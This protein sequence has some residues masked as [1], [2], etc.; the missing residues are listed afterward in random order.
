M[1]R[2]AAKR[3]A[4]LLV[5]VGKHDDSMHTLFDVLYQRRIAI[6]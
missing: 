6:G 5:I 1:V 2:T 3:F 4:G